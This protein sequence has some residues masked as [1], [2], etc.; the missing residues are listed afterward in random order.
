MCK[1][2]TFAV[3][4]YGRREVFRIKM[5]SLVQS[6]KLEKCKFSNCSHLIASHCSFYIHLHMA[7][8]KYHQRYKIPIDRHEISK[9]ID[10]FIYIFLLLIFFYM[11][12]NLPVLQYLSKHVFLCVK[13]HAD[14]TSMSIKYTSLVLCLSGN[15]S[16]VEI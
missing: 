5:R 10:W 8:S 9:I 16:L 4:E 7:P 6:S 12:F 3:H 2:I 15:S 13:Y 1:K 11:T 14:F